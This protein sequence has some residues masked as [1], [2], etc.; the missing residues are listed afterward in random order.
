MPQAGKRL[1]GAKI[2]AW[3]VP[4]VELLSFYQVPD[5]VTYGKSLNHARS[6]Q[7]P[8]ETC[9]GRGISTNMQPLVP[10]LNFGEFFF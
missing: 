10:F 1:N 8:P 7:Q 2:N 9:Q 3:K 5:G 6:T 4:I